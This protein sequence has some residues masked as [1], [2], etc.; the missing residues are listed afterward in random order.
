MAL[1]L[2]PNISYFDKS[3]KES[4]TRSYTLSIQLWL[5][6]LVFTIYNPDRNKFIGLESYIFSDIEN[7][8]QLP[9]YLGQV[10]NNRHSFAFPYSS[11]FLLYQNKF[12]TLIPE[13]LFSEDHKNLYL[14]FNQPFQENSRIV[15]DRLKNNQAVNIYYL[16]NFVVEKAKDFWPNVNLL[17]FSTAMIESLS[18]NFKNKVDKKTLFV[19]LR[20]DCFDVVY[21]KENKLHFYN[22]FDFHTK[23]D[24]IYFLL[25]S[26]EQLMLN[27]EDVNL[28]IS[29]NIKETDQ[30]YKM[31]HQYI[32]NYS[33]ISRND[34][35]SYSFVL[36]ELKYYKYYI[37]FNALQCE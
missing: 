24:F 4:Q 14:G 5:N 22:S 18:I 17:H 25:I 21:F 2:T 8:E 10:L 3:F 36:D 16:P 6:G 31:I 29:G 28:I 12:S 7:V 23:E 20:D 35:Y 37:L 33:F 30:T 15:F 9:S 32:K 11:V 26:I 19:N 27:P 13:A 34:N 1:Q